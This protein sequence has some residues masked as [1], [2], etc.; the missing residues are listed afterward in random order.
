M[1]KVELFF[2]FQIIYL[3][4]FFIPYRLIYVSGFFDVF[5]VGIF[6]PFFLISSPTFDYFITKEEISFSSIRPEHI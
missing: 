4:I 1:V 6:I 5:H 2:I 3:R